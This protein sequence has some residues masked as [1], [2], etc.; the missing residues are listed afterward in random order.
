LISFVARN[1]PRVT[2]IWIVGKEILTHEDILYHSSYEWKK[3]NNA[4]ICEKSQSI[5][6]EF[7]WEETVDIRQ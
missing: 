1:L 3:L 6:E 5:P 2:R 4:F 7:L